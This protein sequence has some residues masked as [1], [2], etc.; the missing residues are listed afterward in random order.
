MSKKLSLRPDICYMLG[1]AQ[2]GRDEPSIYIISKIDDVIERFVKIAMGSFNIEPSKLLSSEDEG[3]KK[4]LFYNSAA[5]RLM[6][7]AIKDRERI[8]KYKNDYSASYF[9]GIYDS[10]GILD[11][12]IVYLG[13]L[14]IVDIVILERLGFHM[15]GRG[16]VRNSKEFMDFIMPYSAKAR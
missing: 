1:V 8:F 6:L 13:R 3:L 7:D 2:F 10:R 5:K 11:G 16:R 4:I 12:K 9:A 14:D 15:A